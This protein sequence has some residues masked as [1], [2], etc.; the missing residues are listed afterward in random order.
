MVF[1]RELGAVL[2]NLASHSQA[3]EAMLGTN[4]DEFQRILA[5]IRLLLP[6]DLL[7]RVVACITHFSE[8]RKALVRR[9]CDSSE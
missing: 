6:D 5:R 2:V 9:L 7:L 3:V 8:G 1:C 4:F